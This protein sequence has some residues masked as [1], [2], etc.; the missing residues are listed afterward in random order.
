M[1]LEVLSKFLLHPAASMTKCEKSEDSI[2]LELTEF[3]KDL[4]ST[5][6]KRLRWLHLNPVLVVCSHNPLKEASIHHCFTW[7]LLLFL[8]LFSFATA[9][10]HTVCWNPDF[11]LYSQTSHVEISVSSTKTH[12]WIKMLHPVTPHPQKPVTILFV[13][14]QEQNLDLN[15]SSPFTRNKISLSCII[16]VTGSPRPS[17][18]KKT[19]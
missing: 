6:F 14:T 12:N 18:L 3:L 17:A 4:C 10:V 1:V 13:Q 11:K 2:S 5:S 15:H 19:M 7:S 16:Q 9:E 8:E